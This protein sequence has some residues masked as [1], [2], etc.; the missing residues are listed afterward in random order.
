MAV[1]DPEV[2]VPR[3][4]SNQSVMDMVLGDHLPSNPLPLTMTT[5]LD[6]K[7][8]AHAEVLIAYWHIFQYL[9]GGILSIVHH[10]EIGAISKQAFKAYQT[11]VH[12][13]LHHV[14]ESSSLLANLLA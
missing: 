10:Q 5:I 13:S 7:S 1:L 9:P 14:T 6:A 8:K 3:G 4:D 12:G 2:E 11:E